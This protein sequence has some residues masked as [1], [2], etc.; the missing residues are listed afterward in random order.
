MTISNMAR[1]LSLGLLVALSAPDS[2]AQEP[3]A[4]V[5]KAA[6][7]DIPPSHSATLAEMAPVKAPRVTCVGDQ[8]TISADNSTLGGV[9]AAVRGCIG[10]QIDIPEGST[11]DRVFAELGPGPA[12]QVLES[13]LSGTELNYVIGSPD[14]DPGKIDS[15]LLM[16]RPADT[17]TPTTVAAGHT[18]S[19]LRRAWM[20]TIQN[21]KA[22]A[23]TSEESSPAEEE[24]T[25]PQ[26]AEDAPP[27]PVDNTKAS[28]PQAPAGDAAPPAA[29]APPPVADTTA[30][31][32][33]TAES[34][35][36]PV[37][38]SSEDKGTS[39]KISDMQQMFEQRRQMN[40]NQS[41]NPTSPQP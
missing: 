23:P 31:A 20:S 26:P 6:E 21:R 12:R 28:G 19:T 9:L 35:S 11:S 24:S 4:P 17:S 14:A 36:V 39:E 38:A 40:Q 8:L 25:E 33:P 15:V 13:L 16:L 10:I 3:L 27:A 41:Q 34:P 18:L 22:G 2:N 30:V 37:P 29:D 1:L 32:P 7:T 5:N